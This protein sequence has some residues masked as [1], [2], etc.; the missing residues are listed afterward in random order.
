MISPIILFTYNRPHHTRQTI[1]ALKKNNLA[2]ESDLIVFSDNAKKDEDIDK[3]RTIRR[4]VKTIHGFKNVQLIERPENIGLAKNIIDGVSTII[5]HYGNAII[6]EDDLVTSPFFLQY[7]NDALRVYEHEEHV[8]SIHGYIYP[9]K[10]KL[11]ETFFIRGADCWGW[12]TWQRGWN[13]FNPDG[14]DLL[15]KIKLRKLEKTFNFSNSFS[16]LK[17]LE[18]QIIG[19]ND[20]W[21]IRWYASAFLADKLTL[22]PGHSLVR[23]IGIDGSGTHCGNNDIAHIPVARTRINV[24]KICIEENIKARKYF[25]KYFRRSKVNPFKA[26]VRVLLRPFK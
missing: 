7:M 20:S 26:T 8:I 23:N 24:K 15:K 14:E 18:D 12:A 4:Y 5:N 6:L 9:M 13:C 2:S 21:A 3:V 25:I 11:P 1:E 19:K 22:Y 10:T 17:M 16:Y